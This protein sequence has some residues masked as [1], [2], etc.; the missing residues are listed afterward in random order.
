MDTQINLSSLEKVCSSCKLCLEHKKTVPRPV[1]GLS[2]AHV[3]NETVPMD[4]N[5]WT[6][7]SSKTWFI[8]MTNHGRYSAS[9]VIKSKR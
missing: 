8:P 6:G 5:E 3:F 9:T 7:G 1:V 4:L 2:Q